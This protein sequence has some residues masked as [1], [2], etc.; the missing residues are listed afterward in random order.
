MSPEAAKGTKFANRT[1]ELRGSRREEIQLS[2]M[3]LCLN[4]RQVGLEVP[5]GNEATRGGGGGAPMARV[6]KTVAMGAAE[7]ARDKRW[8]LNL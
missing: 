1:G 5:A 8:R 4:G 2:L 7:G 6:L 3:L